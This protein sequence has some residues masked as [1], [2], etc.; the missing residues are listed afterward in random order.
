M[1]VASWGLEGSVGVSCPHALEASVGLEG[2]GQLDDRGRRGNGNLRVISQRCKVL[3]M[4]GH[5]EVVL[6]SNRGQ[7]A[8][9]LIP[10]ARGVCLA[11]EGVQSLHAAVVYPRRCEVTKKGFKALSK[12]G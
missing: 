4:G 9:V 10:V 5:L 12:I 3:T 11:L 7:R 2:S 8:M 6:L 1:L